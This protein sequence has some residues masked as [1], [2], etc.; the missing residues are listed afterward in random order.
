V[1]A[2]AT[3]L[4]R[5]P[6]GGFPYSDADWRWSAA[7]LPLIGAAV[8]AVVAG[9][10]LATLRAG[11]LVAAAV[12]VGA[13]LLLTG[14][15]HEDGLADTADALG[16][17]RAVPRERVLAIL[18][19]SRIGAYGSAALTLAIVLRVALLDRLGPAAPA[20][21]VLSASASRLVPVWL[22]ATLPYVTDPT[23]AKS[24]GIAAAGWPQVG[25]ATIWV[26]LTSAVAT[27]MHLVTVVEVVALWASLLVIAMVSRA[28]FRARVGGVTGDFL[29][30]AQ[31]VAECA[32]LLTL[33]IARAGRASAP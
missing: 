24:R 26:G 8:G 1:R 21:L 13:S 19:D 18:K 30:A 27:A 32:V 28:R 33:A 6:V 16:G 3:V 7:H 29:G 17:G 10:W 20:A 12:A 5:A 23:L 11:Y 22:L 14:A 25:V 4:T 2:A 31:Q 9:A 15:I